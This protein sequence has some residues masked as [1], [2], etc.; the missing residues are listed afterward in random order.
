MWRMRKKCLLADLPAVVRLLHIIHGPLRQ[1]LQLKA[2]HVEK[3]HK[4]V[5]LDVFIASSVST[6]DP[7]RTRVLRHG[8]YVACVVCHS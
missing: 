5:D 4:A 1:M 8:C 7:C 2:G 6:H 3:E